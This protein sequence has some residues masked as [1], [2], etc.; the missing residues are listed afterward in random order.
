MDEKK[1]LN[2]TQWVMSYPLQDLT[3][4]MADSVLNPVLVIQCHP[5]D[6]HIRLNFT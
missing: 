5:I 3:F 4:C 2:G 6:I 1:E